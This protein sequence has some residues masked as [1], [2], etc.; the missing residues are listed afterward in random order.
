M[1]WAGPLACLSLPS[2]MSWIRWKLA[3]YQSCSP[4]IK[5]GRKRTS[6]KIRTIFNPT[7]IV[8][9]PIFDQIFSFWAIHILFF[10]PCGYFWALQFLFIRPTGFGLVYQ[11]VTKQRL[12]QIKIQKL[13]KIN[14]WVLLLGLRNFDKYI[15][16]QLYFIWETKILV[17]H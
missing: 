7:Y 13:I 12:W 16:I 8:V 6:H 2:V 1:Y 15:V 4:R 11:L 14:I 10:W 3:L 9:S 17:D 5:E